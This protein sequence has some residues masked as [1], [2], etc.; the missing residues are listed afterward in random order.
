MVVHQRK[1]SEEEYHMLKLHP[2]DHTNGTQVS[3]QKSYLAHH[4]I[5]QSAARAAYLYL[6][7]TTTGSLR[8]SHQEVVLSGNSEVPLHVV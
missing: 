6:L 7:I 8:K 4:V 5:L 2:Y 1:L 3:A